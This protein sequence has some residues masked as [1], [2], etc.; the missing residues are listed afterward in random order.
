MAGANTSYRDLT[1]WQKAMD[2]TEKCYRAMQAFPVEERFGL[3]SQI[4]RSAVS[5]ASNIAEGYGRDSD[6]SFIQFL[7]VS[8][9]SLKE[10]ETQ[11]MVSE[12][13]GILA[14]PLSEALLSMADEIG[15]MLRGLINSIN[16]KGAA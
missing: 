1:V 4:R 15:K 16:K 2:L 7:R 8:Q 3:T 9:G 10:L 12:R 6:G 13:I 5:V 11:I 14:K